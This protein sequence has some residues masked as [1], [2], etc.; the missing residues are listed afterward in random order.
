MSLKVCKSFLKTF[1][2]LVFFSVYAWANSHHHDLNGTWKLVPTRSEFG[3]EQALQMGT[4]T[5][6][7]REH[8]ITI[9]RNFTYEGANQTVS[10]SSSIDGKENASIH[11]GPAFKTKAKWDGDVLKV[12]S[13][14]DGMTTMERFKLSGDGSMMLTVDRPGHRTETLFFE[15]Q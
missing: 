3:G 12:T 11:E 2:A 4:V 15:R 13:T 7:D 6:N 10:Y 8:N 5:I 14:Q 9:S 1:V